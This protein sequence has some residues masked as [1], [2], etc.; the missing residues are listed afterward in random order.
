MTD[1]RLDQILKQALAPEIDD[2]EIKIRRKVRNSTMNMKKIVA[3][4]LVACAA[5]ILVVSGGHFG[6]VSN[7]GGDGIASIN[8]GHN[9]QSGN[10]FAITAYAA[11]LPE[12]VSSGDVMALSA[13]TAGY[14]N[15]AYL[16]GRFAISGQNIEKVKITTDKCNLY[17]VTSVYEGDADFE[18]AQNDAMNGS[19]EYVTIT[20]VGVDYDVENATE[21]TPYHYEH[22]LIVGDTYEDT[23]NDNMLFGMSVPEELWSTNSDIQAAAHEDIDQVN[24]AILT[25]EVTFSDGST[26]THHYRLN[27]GKIF[28]PA[29][30]NGTLQWDNLTRF[31]TS[32]E[33]SAEVGYAYGYLLEKID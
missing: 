2:S 6:D 33:E 1:E 15:A 30:E 10:L 31:I 20:D 11:E 28:V 22:L 9:V 4:G 14:G 23:Y 12:G 17:S 16:D 32:E 5:L 21:P 26:E 29:D 19:G 18:R 8:D 27:T 3:A 25:I 24:G 7:T 13:V